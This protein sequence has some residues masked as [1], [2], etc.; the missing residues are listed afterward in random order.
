L[1]HQDRATAL[2]EKYGESIVEEKTTY[3][4]DNDMIEKYGEVLSN[5]I[6]LS[7][8]IDEDDK[9]K[10]IKAVSVFSI[11]KGTI[12]SMKQYGSIPEIMDEVKPVVALKNVEIIKGKKNY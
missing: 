12:D 1:S 11:S 6:E 10:I 7:N 2:I 5:L 3:S 4:F 8:E 9:A